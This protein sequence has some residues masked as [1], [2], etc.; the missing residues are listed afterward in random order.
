MIKYAILAFILFV[1]YRIFS[2]K[3]LIGGSRRKE[4]DDQEPDDPGYT[5][6]EE[7]D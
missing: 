2:G 4:L 1:A 3:P 6:Y 7:I 5:D